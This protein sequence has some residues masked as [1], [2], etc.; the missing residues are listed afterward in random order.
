MCRSTAISAILN[1]FCFLQELSRS[2]AYFRSNPCL[3]AR[4]SQSI[5]KRNDHSEL[6]DDPSQPE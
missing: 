4:M 1:Y 5:K 2:V 6:E 3:T